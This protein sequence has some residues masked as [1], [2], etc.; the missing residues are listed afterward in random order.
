MMILFL[1]C[2]LVLAFLLY[3]AF[4]RTV[5]AILISIGVVGWFAFSKN[6]TPSDGVTAGL[7]TLIIIA[8]IADIALRVVGV[9]RRR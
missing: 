6:E 9:F 2:G 7:A 1:I 5:W 4:P 3:R 8:F